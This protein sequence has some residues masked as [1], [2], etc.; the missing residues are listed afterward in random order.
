M[1]A[2]E[3]HRFQPLPVLPGLFMPG[4]LRACFVSVGGNRGQEE[5]RFHLTPLLKYYSQVYLRLQLGRELGSPGRKE[6]GGVV[7][8]LSDSDEG[9]STDE[10]KS[11]LY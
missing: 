10:V 5:A 4:Y 2:E 8:I 1:S 6:E 3:L 9:F 11:L 7:R